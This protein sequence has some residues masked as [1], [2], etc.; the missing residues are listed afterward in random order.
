MLEYLPILFVVLLVASMGLGLLLGRKRAIAQLGIAAGR[1]QFR[2]GL[3]CLALLIAAIVVIV[4]VFW[5]LPSAS[6]DAILNGALL[7][8]AALMLGYVVVR[9]F[10]RSR[11]GPVVMKLSASKHDK[12]LAVLG[13]VAIAWGLMSL[14]RV[15]GMEGFYADAAVRAAFWFSLG[16]AFLSM[17][18]SRFAIHRGGIATLGAIVPWDRILSYSWEGP[19]GCVLKIRFRTRL[20]ADRVVYWRI[21]PD[22]RGSVAGLFTQNVSS[23]EPV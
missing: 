14:L 21:P 4:I 9:G 20:P 22:E 1:E 6:Q 13:I 23:P 8:V 7:I 16:L 5:L 11:L 19:E 18:L 3:P 2:R 15:R 10:L 17:G 12:W